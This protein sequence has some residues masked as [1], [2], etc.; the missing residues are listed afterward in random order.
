MVQNK[1]PTN[2]KPT[3]AKPTYGSDQ[4]KIMRYLLW[5]TVLLAAVYL[6]SQWKFFGAI[7]YPFFVGFILANSVV[8]YR[9]FFY[10]RDKLPTL[11]GL[12]QTDNQQAEGKL[13][14]YLSSV[15]S[16]AYSMIAAVI[17][18]CIIAGSIY[19]L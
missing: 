12:M 4:S 17:Y 2:G 8:V 19:F 5:I 15:F 3:T 14:H 10:L 1:K 7:R 16:P 11:I 9:Y 6:Y 13:Q 18:G